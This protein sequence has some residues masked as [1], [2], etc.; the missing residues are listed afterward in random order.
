MYR[1]GVYM[2]KKMNKVYAEFQIFLFWMRQLKCVN[3]FV[4]YLHQI[5]YRRLIIV[6]V[7]NK[8]RIVLKCRGNILY[9]LWKA[10]LTVE[11]LTV[12]N[13]YQEKGKPRIRKNL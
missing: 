11:S 13:R 12:F 10:R 1:Y 9:E 3:L 5:F 2:L 7:V 6:W 8:E 4:N